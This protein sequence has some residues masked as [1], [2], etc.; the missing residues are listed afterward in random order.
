MI[1]TEAGGEGRNFQFCHIIMNYDLPWNP[2]KIEQRI[3]RL[4]RIGQKHPVTVINFSL[5][6]TIEERVL[7]VL[8]HRIQVF[9]QTIGGLD[10][11]LG[12]VEN[13]IKNIFLLA[14]NEAERNRALAKLDKDLE[15]RI[16]EAILHALCLDQGFIP[17]SK[18]HLQRQRNRNH[19]F[20]I[21]TC[22]NKG[23][24]R[25]LFYVLLYIHALRCSRNYSF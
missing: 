18:S 21:N 25:K 5:L 19:S 6:G 17:W 16:F 4:D 9:E 2:M 24:F 8:H 3:G 23:M 10:P 1:S 15:A 7:D 20:S 11:I 13:S 22:L 14:E 12:D